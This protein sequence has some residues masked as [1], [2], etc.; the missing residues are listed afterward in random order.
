VN[1]AGFGPSAPVSF[2]PG[3]PRHAEITGS[4]RIPHPLRSAVKLIPVLL[5]LAYLVA[6]HVYYLRQGINE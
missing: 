2:D 3:D 6:A 1:G 4:T 5:V